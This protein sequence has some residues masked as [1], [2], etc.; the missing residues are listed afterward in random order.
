MP[1]RPLAALRTLGVA[2]VLVTAAAG[3][4]HTVA[5]GRADGAAVFAEAC[6]RC[7]GPGGKPEESM[8]AQL[9]VRDLTAA[10][11]RARASIDLV[12]NQVRQG[13]ANKIMPAFVGALNDAQIDAV[14]AYVLTLSDAAATTP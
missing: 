4:D 14:A 7:H 6:A 3:C 2:I 9:G 11:F 5:G 8:R 10:E 12:R 1:S 13:S